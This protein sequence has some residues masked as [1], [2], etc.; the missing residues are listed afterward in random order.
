M[1]LY[2][3]TQNYAELMEMVE[4]VDGQAFTDTLA[5]LEEEINEKAENIAKFIR[6]LEAERDAFKAEIDRL[7]AKKSSRD[8][9]IK[10]LKEYLQF[11]LEKAKIK[12]VKGSILTV[13]LQKNAPSLKTEDETHIPK[14]FYVEQEPKLD[15]KLLL[16]HIKA[17][18]EIKGV[19]MVQSESIRI[20]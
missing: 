14:E 15:R 5:T 16:T 9:K 6:N 17:G 19:E 18:H 7:A 20:R 3:L 10:S 11:E 8:N 2:E 13:A 1:K 4:E 12:K